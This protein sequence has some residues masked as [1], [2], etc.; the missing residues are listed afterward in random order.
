MKKYRRDESQN[1]IVD[2]AVGFGTSFGF[3]FLVGI[4]FTVVSVL[5]K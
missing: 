3:F 5:H 1:D 4:I 2:N